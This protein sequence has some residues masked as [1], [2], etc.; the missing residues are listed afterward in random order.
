LTLLTLLLYAALGGLTVLL[1]FFL[2]RVAGYSA[3][4]A[5]A[6]M[7]PI[8]IV[9]GAG[10]R[11]VEHFASSIGPRR[12]LA[13]GSLVVA[14]GMF[15]YVRVP[16][17]GVDYWRDVLPAT[18]LVAAGMA[19]CVAPLTVA[20]MDSVDATHIGAASGINSAT[21]RVGGLVASAL[22]AF[23]FVK[24]GSNEELIEGFRNAAMIGAAT[25]VAAAASAALLIRDKGAAT[26]R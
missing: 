4:A 16:P 2:I 26:K 7:L 14:A 1:P 12:L 22:L 3:S 13:Y 10:S 9:I 18:L 21:A 17:D 24:Q 25:C 19:F 15:L 6:A 8:P 20:V 11:M 5:G 23:I